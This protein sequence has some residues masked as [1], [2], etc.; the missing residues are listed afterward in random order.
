[1]LFP[2]KEW[3]VGASAGLQLHDVAFT[4]RCRGKDFSSIVLF[5]KDASD[6]LPRSGF[7]VVRGKINSLLIA[8]PVGTTKTLVTYV[9]EMDVR[10]LIAST[11]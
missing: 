4:G 5:S 6:K 2:W 1:M 9:V 8:E 7:N 3:C 11:C 10:G